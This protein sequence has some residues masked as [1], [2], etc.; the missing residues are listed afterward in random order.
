MEIYNNVDNL[1]NLLGIGR[2]DPA[3]GELRPSGRSAAAATED[4]GGA[5]RATLSSAAS[6]AAGMAGAD[7]VR[8]EKVAVVQ[9]AL[10][11]GT[12]SVSS[13]AV[14]SKLVDSMLGAGR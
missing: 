6:E 7:G 8:T 14:A 3:G 4:A 12:Y 1:R 2:A 13:A 11:S 9:A 5:D 10:A